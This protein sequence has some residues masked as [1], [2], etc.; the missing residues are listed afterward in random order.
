MIPHEPW[1]DDAACQGHPT[2]WWFPKQGAGVPRRALAICHA[3]P[4]KTDCAEHARTTPELFG[5]WGGVHLGLR[6]RWER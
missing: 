4:V 1:R 5:V 3:C 6:R 2:E